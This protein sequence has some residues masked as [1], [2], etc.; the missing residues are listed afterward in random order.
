MNFF[1]STDVQLIEDDSSKEKFFGASPMNR[2][3]VEGGEGGGGGGHDAEWDRRMKE[4]LERMKEKKMRDMTITVSQKAGLTGALAS[5]QRQRYAGDGEILGA[6]TGH[7]RI[8][9]ELTKQ[10][11]TI[12][13]LTGGD[14]G[15]VDICVQSIVANRNS[16]SRIAFNITMKA[17]DDEEERMN[18]EEE[19]DAIDD[20]VAREKK[21]KEKE[22][23]KKKKKNAT[24]DHEVAKTQMSRLERDITTLT[25][26]VRSL[27][28][29]A[30]YN[31]NQ[32]HAFMDQSISM[33]SAATYWPII[34][35]LII[36]ITGITQADHIIRYMRT[37]H[38]GI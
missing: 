31:K 32:Q 33:H 25:S 11:G 7:G 19:D 37:R 12:E 23:A 20:E 28:N 4:K 27:L 30:D 13:F 5:R 24:E 3:G 2:V 18:E 9:E 10:Y 14:D 1:S 6:I 22:E 15:T 35:V 26:R 38:I 16:P 8:R 29:N 36:I 21:K 34:Q 17:D